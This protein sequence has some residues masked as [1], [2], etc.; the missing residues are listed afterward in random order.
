MLSQTK[1]TRLLWSQFPYHAA[2]LTCKQTLMHNRCHENFSILFRSK[3][4]PKGIFNQ[5]LPLNM[6]DQMNVLQLLPN[7]LSYSVVLHFFPKLVLLLLDI[8]L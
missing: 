5:S 2:A 7:D 6:T 8:K 3:N 4:K 1:H